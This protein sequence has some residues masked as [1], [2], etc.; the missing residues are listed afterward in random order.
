MG[1]RED[2]IAA[3]PEWRY[4]NA[5]FIKAI[6]KILAEAANFCSIP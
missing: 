6:I 2:I 5:K 3:V 1:K 4:I